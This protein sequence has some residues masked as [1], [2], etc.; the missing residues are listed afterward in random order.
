MSGTEQKNQPAPAARGLR[1]YSMSKARSKRRPT[2][3]RRSSMAN[4]LCVAEPE[5]T[6]MENMLRQFWDEHAI[7]TGIILFMGWFGLA[8]WNA[9]QGLMG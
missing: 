9:L 2:F 8:N 1:I 7:K 5:M 3:Y 4:D 6:E